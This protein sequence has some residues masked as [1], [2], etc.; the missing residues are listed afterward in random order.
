MRS[1]RVDRDKPWEF[2]TVDDRVDDLGAIIVTLNSAV[3][4]EK[5]MPDEI[6]G[7]VAAKQID[8]LA[9]RLR[10]IPPS[11][12]RSAIRVALIHHHPI[13]IPDLVEPGRDYDAV[14]NSAQLL[15]V[16]RKFGFHLLLH[17]H[18]HNPH[19]FTEDSVSAYRKG[20]PHPILIVAGGSVGSDELPPRS[21]NCYNRIVVKWNPAADQTRV[22]VTTRGLRV[23]DD[24][25]HDLLPWDWTWQTMRVDDRQFIGGEVL[26]NGR[27][28]QARPFD[29]SVDAPAETERS[30]EY[31]RLRFYF[32]VAAVMPSLQPGQVNEAR[33]WIVRHNPPEAV[34]VG[35]PS[36]ALRGP[37]AS[38]SPS[39]WWTP[40]ESARATRIRICPAHLGAG[41]FNHGRSQTGY[42][43]GG[44]DRPRFPWAGLTRDDRAAGTPLA[45]PPSRSGSPTMPAA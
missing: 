12:L 5:N 21:G 10:A 9:K 19:V 14:H 36:V 27:A 44:Q 45:G 37:P 16:L 13:L 29:A 8:T 22:C 33:V 41:L 24:D 35:Q 3:Y 38:G 32:P 4:V 6:R 23:V 20:E 31:Q 42:R 40:T 18:K 28:E 26:P 25:E 11:R 1:T 30:A 39:S 43:L 2:D 34:D 17:G 7:R 15:T